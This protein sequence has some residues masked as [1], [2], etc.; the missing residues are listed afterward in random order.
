MRRLVLFLILVVGI[1]NLVGCSGYRIIGINKDGTVNDKAVRI[2]PWERPIIVSTDKQGNTVVIDA[3]RPGENYVIT[4]DSAGNFVN[5]GATSYGEY[6]YG[7]GNSGRY[8]RNNYNSRYY[9]NGYGRCYGESMHT[10]DPNA[11][12]RR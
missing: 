6:G 12:H 1:G 7:Y 8:Y 3:S 11:P 2:N 9:R 5:K 10:F 4:E